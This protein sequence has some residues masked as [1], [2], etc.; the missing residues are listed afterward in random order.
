MSATS[1]QSIYRF[2]Q[3]DPTLFM[4]KGKNAFSDGADAPR[5]RIDLNRNYRSRGTVLSRRQ[6]RVCFRSCARM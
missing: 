4:A 6:P 5:R 1:K 3:A 2:R